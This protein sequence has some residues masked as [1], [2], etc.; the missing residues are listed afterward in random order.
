LAGRLRGLLVGL[1]V[2]D[3]L[4]L[5]FEGLAPGR[6]RRL[7]PGPMRHRLC[8]GH[9]LVSD[10]TEHA[11]FAAQA[12]LAHPTDVAAFK[13]A[14]SWKLRWWLVGLPAG[15][16]LATLRAILRM[17]LG[18]ERPGVH[19]AGNGPAMRA[20][21][22][23]AALAQEPIRL[24]AYVT[25]ST[26]LTH[27]DPRALT[28]ALALAR[29][30]A[31]AVST[32]RPPSPADFEALWGEGD[33]EWA[34]WGTAIAAHRE[35]GTSLTG[36]ARAQGLGAGVTGYMVHSVAIAAYAWLRYGDD[37]EAVVAGV[38]GLGGDTDSVASFAGALAGASAGLAGIPAA[39]R[40]GIWDWPRG[41]G[42]YLEVADRLAGATGG[43]VT[44]FWPGLAARNALLVAA[45]L[46]H[47]LRRW[48]PPYGVE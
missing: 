45:V 26:T 41:E 43:P 25:A 33:A 10:D 30:A 42:V 29:M 32:D 39:W 17:W 21:V 38:V 6:A 12:L 11:L 1:A 37:F 14:L 35:R 27:T 18:F 46:A 40:E 36:F 48:L 28:G 34:G 24:L 4:G 22:L 20:A 8:F 2:G 23:G 3:A 15:I 5:P 13:R 44:Y 19:S 31:W 47:G 16:G 7:L 9:G